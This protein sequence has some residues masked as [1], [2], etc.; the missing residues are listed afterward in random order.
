MARPPTSEHIS[1]G[2]Q[3]KGP[4]S[5]TGCSVAKDSQGAM[6]FR[7][8]EGHTQV[9]WFISAAAVHFTSPVLTESHT[10]EGQD[11]LPLFDIHLFYFCNFITIF[12]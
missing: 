4:S 9:S 2:T 12:M 11:T 8:T 3:E 10:A 7:G 5:A 1:A 6:S